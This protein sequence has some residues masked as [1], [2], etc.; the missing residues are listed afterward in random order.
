[1]LVGNGHSLLVV[2]CFTWLLRAVL[3]E[4][5]LTAFRGSR[6]HGVTCPTTHADRINCGFA[7]IQEEQCRGSGCCY[8]KAHAVGNPSCFFST[9]A[10][11]LAPGATS[12]C[13]LPDDDRLECGHTGITSDECHKKGCCY[14]HAS[15]P[16]VPFCFFRQHGAPRELVRRGEQ[17]SILGTQRI[18]CGWQGISRAQCTQKGC[19]YRD[20]QTPGVPHCY[21]TLEDAP[22]E[23][24]AEVEQCTVSDS[25]KVDC[26]VHGITPDDCQNQ[27]CCYMHSLNRGI[28]YCFYKKGTKS[29]PTP[30]R[31]DP[32]LAHMCSAS[33]FDR[34]DC[35]FPGIT[36]ATC[37]TKGCCYAHSPVKGAPFC[38]Y[39][40]DPVTT[41]TQSIAQSTS[42]VHA[43][44]AA[45]PVT[46]KVS[47]MSSRPTLA[48]TTPNAS[49]ASGL[50]SWG[51]D[52]GNAQAAVLGSSQT[53]PSNP[54]WLVAALTGVAAL[55]LLIMAYV[56]CCRSTHK[57]SPLADDED[58][59]LFSQVPQ[60]IECKRLLPDSSAYQEFHRLF[61]QKWDTKR[62]PSVVG[63][64]VPSPPILEIFEVNA[65]CQAASYR[66]K[67]RAINLQLG[68]REGKRPGNE[69]RRFY[70][71]RMT[72][73]FRGAPCRD[74]RCAVCRV[75]EHGSFGT[76][77]ITS[78]GIRFSAGAHT[79]KGQGLAPGKEP[80]PANLE[81]FVGA[82]A[83]NAVF[84]ADVLLG[85]PQIVSSHTNDALRA[86]M[87]S[88][89][90]DQACGV[91]EIVIFDGAQALP[92]ALIL[93]A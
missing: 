60:E 38:F 47:L 13:T 59:L 11:A 55:T 6:K 62:W 5:D 42:K 37:H 30:V 45:A 27:G 56:G 70:G 81:H 14:F 33:G 10:P 88:C 72:C 35:G 83:G 54:K 73:E 9:N 26:G 17:C 68:P 58:P 82:A 28:P 80:P 67:Q 53:A 50:P 52:I 8:A 51:S 7:G 22:A 32:S 23:R 65:E 20:S 78:T 76:D 57:E 48:V 93:F 4:D 21:Y 44:A 90:A 85:R 89:I 74:P 69:K 61:L 18:N 2:G 3:G 64:D 87:H 41:T 71:A 15:T 92:R 79:A 24:V 19:C 66:D 16:G 25:E 1:M 39:K 86:G 31:T 40:S 29:G 84:V 34:I 12:K 75:V 36:E 77:H 46:T 91:D 49:A 43:S 63:C